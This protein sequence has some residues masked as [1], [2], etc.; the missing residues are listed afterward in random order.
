MFWPLNPLFPLES[1]GSQSRPLLLSVT[2]IPPPHKCPHQLLHQLLPLALSPS[3]GKHPPLRRAAPLTDF[4]QSDAPT[5]L[6][7]HGRQSD[8]PRLPEPRLQLQQR[9]PGAGHHSD[10]LQGQV[11]QKDGFSPVR[12]W[13]C[14]GPGQRLEVSV[15]MLSKRRR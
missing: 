4:S 6:S 14:G 9:G 1:V 8:P 15:H 2:G 13:L 7:S 10:G 11:E 3:Q 12:H 5:G